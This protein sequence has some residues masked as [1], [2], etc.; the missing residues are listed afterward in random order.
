V[1][2]RPCFVVITLGCLL[3]LATSASAE[4]A[5]VS[6]VQSAGPSGW[7][8]IAIDGWKD[9]EECEKDRSRRMQQP[10]DPAVPQHR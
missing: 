8:H 2:R 1:T 3:A 6:W 5:W 10:K 4:C 7:T 9:R